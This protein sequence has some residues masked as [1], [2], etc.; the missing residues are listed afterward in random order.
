[1]GYSLWWRFSWTNANDISSNNTVV[2]TFSE[3]LSRMLYVYQLIA[4]MPNPNINGQSDWSKALSYRTAA[5]NTIFT[6]LRVCPKLSTIEFSDTSPVFWLIY[7][8]VI[9]L[10]HIWIYSWGLG[11]WCMTHTHWPAFWCCQ[12]YSAYLRSNVRARSY[13]FNP[14]LM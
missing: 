2:N 1:M 7:N 8:F 3:M 6:T 5:T 12:C 13:Y 14:L 4:L 10:H 9:S 11:L